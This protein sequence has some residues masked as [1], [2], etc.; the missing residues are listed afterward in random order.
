MPEQRCWEFKKCGRQPGGSKAGE[1][2]VCPAAAEALTTGSHPERQGCLAC[3]AITGKFS[4]EGVQG[5][6]ERL[7]DCIRC[8]YLKQNESK[9]GLYDII[10][11]EV[12]SLM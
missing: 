2:G 12:I 4:G 11:R 1:L 3:W 9:D 7:G 8:D 10:V 6:P 5:S